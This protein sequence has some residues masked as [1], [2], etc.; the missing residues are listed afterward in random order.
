MKTQTMIHR[1]LVASALASAS[2][3]AACG[4]G[5][6]G[7]SPIPG[8]PAGKTASNTPGRFTVFVPSGASSQSNTRSPRYIDGNGTSSLVVAVTPSDPAELAQFGT[9]KVCYNLFTNGTATPSTGVTITPVIGPP[10]GFNV[11]FSLPSPPGQDAVV[12]TQYAGLCLPGNPYAAPTPAPGSPIGSNII[13]QAPSINVVITAGASNNYNVQLAACSTTPGA[14]TTTQ[15]VS[16]ICPVPNPGGTTTLTPTLGASIGSVYMAGSTPVA[17]PLAAPI[18]VLPI[19]APIREQGAFI[20]AGNNIGIPI[21][22]LGLDSN[23][24]PVPYTAGVGGL[25]ASSGLLPKPGDNITLAH[26]EVGAGGLHGNLVMIDATTGALVQKEGAG[27][28]I[29]LTQ[30]NAIAAADITY[31]GAHGAGGGT[32]G[33][34]YVVAMTYDGTAATKLTS[35]T[36]TLNA[37]I[38]TAAIAA[39]TLT[40]APQAALYSVGAPA[41]G[42]GYADAGGPYVAAADVKNLFGVATGV[43]QQVW[44]TDGGKMAAVGVGR[45]TVAGATKLTGMNYDSNAAVNQIVAV[46]SSVVANAGQVAPLASGIYLFDPILHTSK[47]VALQSHTSSN[48]IA[49]Q[50]PVGAA[51]IANGYV[52]IAENNNIVAIDPTA[53]GGALTTIGAGAFYEAEEIGPLNIAGLSLGTSGI[54]MLVS[55]TKLIVADTG[56]NRVIAVDTATCFPNGAACV[57]TVLASGQAF[58]GLAVNGTNVVAT[59][60][61]GQIYQ[62]PLSGGAVTSFGLTT[63]GVADGVLGVLTPPAAGAAPYAVQGQPANFFGSAPTPTVPYNI[64]PFSAAGPVF[65]APA[66]A[67]ISGAPLK[68]APDTSNATIL[69]TAAGKVGVPFGIVFVP[70]ANAAGNGALTPD[71]YLFSDTGNIRT[72]V[73]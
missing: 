54:G 11:S 8:Q 5:G 16:G 10:A 63:G 61:G 20:A 47:P 72:L 64:S 69:A 42:N 46:D 33:D 30:I 65:T 34:P 25:P 26:T 71:S 45:F 58:A 27:A 49:Y 35:F 41:P 53:S 37:T 12:I 60:T 57:P 13:A 40:I 62:F 73:P 32:A 24:Y 52:Y 39:Q 6:G 31:G 19:P 59:T 21:P 1:L 18:P 51:F 50:K 48:F 66:R 4:G 3:L 15:P 36:V 29:T 23:G 68:F 55:G 38:N 22:V 7:S 17:S 14:P 28:P 2:I 9:L 67:A 70:A 44:V 43:G 56:N